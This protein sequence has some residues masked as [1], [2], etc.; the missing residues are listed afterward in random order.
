MLSFLL[1]VAVD[2]I[3][4]YWDYDPTISSFFSK[5]EVILIFLIVGLVLITAT[6][7]VFLALSRRRKQKNKQKAEHMGSCKFDSRFRAVLPL[8][9]K[10]FF[11]GPLLLFC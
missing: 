1:D 8:H 6:I 9:S 5:L 3:D 4:T 2:P 10:K 11:Q 7:V